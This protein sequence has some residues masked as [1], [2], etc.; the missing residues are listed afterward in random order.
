MIVYID[1]GLFM[2]WA[3]LFLFAVAA[4]FWE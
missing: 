2:I 1:V 4:W 3:G